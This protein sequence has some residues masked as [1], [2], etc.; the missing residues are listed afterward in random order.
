MIEDEDVFLYLPLVP[1]LTGGIY[2]LISCI[3]RTM[4]PLPL[5]RREAAI[6]NYS[7]SHPGY[8]DELARYNR[9]KC[10]K[11]WNKEYKKQCKEYRERMNAAN[12]QNQGDTNPMA[13][14]ENS[15]TTSGATGV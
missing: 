4:I 9:K 10:Q 8:K 1:I 14:Q 11:K 3:S 5:L 7:E 15:D 6:D 13:D 12:N 2:V